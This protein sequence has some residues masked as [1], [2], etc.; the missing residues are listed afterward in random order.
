MF[1]FIRQCLQC[2]TANVC[3]LY[4]SGNLCRMSSW[5]DVT[6]IS[7]AAK[8][9][10]GHVCQN[11][12]AH[13]TTIVSLIKVIEII[14]ICEVPQAPKT[15]HMS[16]ISR[17]GRPKGATDEVN[18]SVHCP[19]AEGHVAVINRRKGLTSPPIARLWLR[20]EAK[21]FRRLLNLSKKRSRA[22]TNCK[23]HPNLQLSFWERKLTWRKSERSS[24][25]TNK[26]FHCEQ[27]SN[28]FQGNHLILK[29]TA[30][31]HPRKWDIIKL[32]WYLHYDMLSF[33]S[34]AHGLH[35]LQCTVLWLYFKVLTPGAVFL[36]IGQ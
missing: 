32:S 2:L 36:F 3:R 1:L 17:P 35:L 8:S 14:A 15:Q 24:K 25:M 31:E 28:T 16:Y 34:F 18:A 13:L 7:W 6:G 22:A 9:R 23:C 27:C 26:V 20:A 29:L 11:H 33:E 4:L 19:V 12:Q 5:V 30:S 21:S 10:D